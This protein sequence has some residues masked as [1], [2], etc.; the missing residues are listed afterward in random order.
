MVILEGQIVTVAG[1]FSL[2]ARSMMWRWTS[3]WP[4]RSHMLNCLFVWCKSPQT[5]V[6]SSSQVLNGLFVWN[7]HAY[8]CS[9]GILRKWKPPK[10]KEELAAEKEAKDSKKRD[11]KTEKAKKEKKEKTEKVKSEP[12]S[13]KDDSS[14]EPAQRLSSIGVLFVCYLLDRVWVCPL[15]KKKK[16]KKWSW[17]VSSTFGWVGA[18]SIILQ[19]ASLYLWCTPHLSQFMNECPACQLMSAISDTLIRL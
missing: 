6:C 3:T 4:V 18:T 7:A 11:K 19:W 14:A 17:I 2:S 10:S 8:S 9:S 5:H 12:G 1:L 15:R 13:P 16:T